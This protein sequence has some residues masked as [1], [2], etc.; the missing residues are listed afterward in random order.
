MQQDW[1]KIYSTDQLYKALLMKEKLLEEG[2]HAFIVNK[3][4][5]IYAFGDVDLYVKPDLA[6]LSIHIIKKSEF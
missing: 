2:I 6:V 1:V 5:S 4:D 3:R